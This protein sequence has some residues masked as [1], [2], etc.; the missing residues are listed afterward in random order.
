LNPRPG[1]DF[2]KNGEAREMFVEAR[3]QN[4]D[5]RLECQVELIVMARERPVE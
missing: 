5:H 1:N 3:L 2:I 4:S